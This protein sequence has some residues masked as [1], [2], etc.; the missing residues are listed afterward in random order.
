M[1]GYFIHG[2]SLR[3]EIALPAHASTDR[4]PWFEVKRGEPGARWEERESWRCLAAR[5]QP[6]RV[7]VFDSSGLHVVN[8]DV[9]QLRA[10]HATRTI[11]VVP[12]PA[13][14]EDLLP[15]LIWGFGLSALLALDGELVLHASAVLFPSG[16]VVFAGA[17]GAGK[18]T[19]AASLATLGYPLLADDVVCVA[20]SAR[21]AHAHRGA[22]QV[23]VRPFA[24]CLAEHPGNASHSTTDGRIAVV[25]KAVADCALA[26]IRAVVLPRFARETRTSV[27]TLSGASSML[28]VLG[29]LRVGSWLDS[30]ISARQMS[31]AA[32]LARVVP[33]LELTVPWRD[34]F[35]LAM[36]SEVAECLSETLGVR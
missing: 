18:S 24:A 22:L 7:R 32:Q 5:D 20:L 15:A 16:A 30:G 26:P 31:L 4:Q 23:R 33:L 29:N 35:D 19:L 21:C 8:F 1:N 11:H 10:E 3:S 12:E 17:R 13:C 28:S 34:Q 36:A 6:H 2:R 9:L 27:H 25:P 14:A